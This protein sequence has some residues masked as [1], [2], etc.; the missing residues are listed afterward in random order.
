MTNKPN[1]NSEET[2]PGWLEYTLVLLATAVVTILALVFI[3]LPVI[4]FKNF[5]LI[6][7]CAVGGV[8][9]AAYLFP[10]L[11]T[12][13]PSWIGFIGGFVITLIVFKWWKK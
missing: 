2:Q 11:H 7:T 12:D 5:L 1:V 13:L 6:F 9:S 3:K 8:I 4:I 10:M